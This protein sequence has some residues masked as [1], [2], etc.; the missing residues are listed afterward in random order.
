MASRSEQKE[1]LRQER[2]A[3]QEAEQRKARAVQFGAYG[4][5]GL[6]TA[7]VIV[8]IVVVI[9]GGS[10]GSSS[11]EASGA[12][13]PHYDGLKGRLAAADVPTMMDTMS[14]SSHI[15]PRV[16]VYANGKQVPVSP[17]IGI[18][19]SQPP[20]QMAD[21]HTHDSSGTIHDEGMPDSRLAQFFAVWGVPFS[22]RQLGPYRAQGSNRV[23]MWV[24]GKSSKAFGSLR[25]KDKQRIVVAYGTAAQIPSGVRS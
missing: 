10:A 22:E 13:G 14:A 25:L 3:Q 24:D 21:L 19:P 2:L 1:R 15:H 11:A 7:G 18:D 20:M 8:G 5:A 17:N 23:R 4:L 16:A 6:L 12:F 9:V